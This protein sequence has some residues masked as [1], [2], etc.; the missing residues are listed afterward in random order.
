MLSACPVQKS[1]HCIKYKKLERPSGQT[2][3][4]TELEKRDRHPTLLMLPKLKTY[5]PLLQCSECV[6]SKNR[7]DLVEVSIFYK[8]EK[9]SSQT[10]RL[11][12]IKT[13]PPILP[14]QVVLQFL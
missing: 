9:M 12:K 4:P 7:V 13:W 6:Q 11:I 1:S 2:V 8:V 3:Q 5:S 10:V 14:Q